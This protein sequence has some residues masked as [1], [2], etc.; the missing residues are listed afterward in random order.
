MR[1]GKALFLAVQGREDDRM[2]IGFSE[3]LQVPEHLRQGQERGYARSVAVRTGIQGS[4]ECADMVEMRGDDHV[5]VPAAGKEA[6]DIMG[7]AA[8]EGTETVKVRA[9]GGQQAVG[10]ELAG[11]GRLCME[12]ARS[13][14]GPAGA[15]TVCEER[16]AGAEP[17]LVSQVLCVAGADKRTRRLGRRVGGQCCEQEAG[18]QKFSGHPSEGHDKCLSL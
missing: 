7:G 12:G 5:T 4:G 3:V 1:A 9:S 18:A 13:P 11:D 15:E 8:G 17:G 10:R 14:R 6:H 2:G 16:H